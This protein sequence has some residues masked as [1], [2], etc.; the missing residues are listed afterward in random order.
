MSLFILCSRI[1]LGVGTPRC[2]SLGVPFK[3]LLHLIFLSTVEG[4]D[5]LRQIVLS[6]VAMRHKAHNCLGSPHHDKSCRGPRIASGDVLS[7]DIRMSS[8]LEKQKSK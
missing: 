3:A 4:S 2:A 5:R 7:K 1:I 6:D 8:G